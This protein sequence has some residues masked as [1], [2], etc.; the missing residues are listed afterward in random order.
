[1]RRAVL[2]SK[3]RVGIAGDRRGGPG[4][5]GSRICDWESDEGG[6]AGRESRGGCAVWEVD[7][8][9][10]PAVAGDGEGDGEGAIL[11]VW[12]V[13]VEAVEEAIE[14]VEA[15]TWLWNQRGCPVGA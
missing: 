13:M 4:D 2:S 9:A 15:G 7:V 1:M 12:E 3:A 11:G 5:G 6:R 14:A 10:G 8:V